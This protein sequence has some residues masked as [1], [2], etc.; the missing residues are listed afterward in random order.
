MIQ[1]NLSRVGPRKQGR[2]SGEALAVLNEHLLDAAERL[3]LAQGFAATSMDQIACEARSSKRTI[4]HRYPSKPIL[5]KAVGERAVTRFVEGGE[6]EPHGATIEAR[7]EHLALGLIDFTL[8]PNV[9]ALMRIVMAEALR[10][11]D[12]ALFLDDRSRG[13]I[14]RFIAVALEKEVER[15]ILA[16]SDPVQSAAQQF[17]SLTSSSFILRALLGGEAEALRAEAERMA[18]QAVR[19]FLRGCLAR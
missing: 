3:F 4:Y 15:G 16:F 7:L 8:R 18:P 19:L 11:T 6:N 10:F 17:L 13:R 14:V 5:F 2:P 1:R 9:L 12:V